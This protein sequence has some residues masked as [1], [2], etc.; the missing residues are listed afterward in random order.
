MK[1]MKPGS[2]KVTEMS[3]SENAVSEVVDFVLI[4]GIMLLAISIITL[5]GMPAL[6][7]LQ[8]NGHTENIKQSHI[9]LADNINKIVFGNTPSQ[10]VELKMYGGGGVWVIG[11]SSINVTIQTWNSSNS[12]FE[13][14]S[15]TR[16]LREI[17][18]EFETTAISY[19]NTGVWAKYDNQGVVIV[20][21]PRFTFSDN[22]M[23]IPAAT[24]LGTNGMSG[25]G[26]IRVV[27]DGGSPSLFSYSN[28]SSVDIKIV[29]NYYEG[30]E[31]YLNESLGMHLVSKDD[32]N[33]TILMR[34]DN[35]TENIDVYIKYSPI[36]ATIK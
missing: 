13:S 20:K 17:R 6:T 11:D 3:K 34:R 30:W 1:I 36:T 16:Q 15:F 26:L 5:F 4:L 12:S 32:A 28:V 25:E 24:L 9:V 2:K 33:K 19:E 22:I 7:A 21:E 14:E 23:I 18:S 29:S 10:S 35:F 8:D 31:K 27:A